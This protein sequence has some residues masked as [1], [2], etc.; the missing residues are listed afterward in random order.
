MMNKD[1]NQKTQQILNVT[2][3]IIY[4]LIGEEYIIVKK[5]VER[6]THNNTSCVSEV[7]WRTQRP[8]VGLLPYSQ[9]QEKNNDKTILELAN[10]IIHLLTGELSNT[11]NDQYLGGQTDVMK[12]HH[13][14][15]SEGCVNEETRTKNN[16]DKYRRI[17]TSNMSTRNLEEESSSCDEETSSDINTSMDISQDDYIAIIIKEESTSHDEDTLTDQDMYSL[18]EHTKDGYASIRIKEEYSS[19]EGNLTD[20]EL[21][22]PTENTQEDVLSICVKEESDLSDE[23]NLTDT[24]K[25]AAPEHTLKDYKYK[26]KKPNVSIEKCSKCGKNF[27]KKSDFIS[28]ESTHSKEKL[29]NNSECQTCNLD[30]I[31]EAVHNRKKLACSVCGKEFSYKSQLVT[32]QRNHTGEKPFSCSECGKS[33]TWN[34]HLAAHVRIHT[35]EKPFSC[36]LCERSF[37]NSASLIAHQRS[38][39]GEKPFSCLVCGKCFTNS[40]YLVTHQRIHTG[41]K[42]FSCTE[43]GKS[44]TDKSSFIRHLRIH[45]GEKPFSCS[46]CGKCFIEKGSLLRHQ[47]IHTKK[48]L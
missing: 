11:G 29:Y 28:P 32:H 5:S 24:D 25:P 38:H 31:K 35:G 4:L 1:K 36:S 10:T 42:P 27:N 39:T 13:L 26:D 46:V 18:A 2:L 41:E 16:G 34:S 30:R 9:Q 48:K 19:E 14:H 12:N 44:F 33:F 40:T 8:I 7:T 22:I 6:S 47:I 37:T 23:D 15:D 3:D 20:N 43:C 21:N 17:N 45:T